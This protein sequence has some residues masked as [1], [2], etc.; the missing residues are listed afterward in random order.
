LKKRTIFGFKKKPKKKKFEEKTF[1][2]KK[3]EKVFKKKKIKSKNGRL[4]KKK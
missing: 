1:L 3:L 2:K 4:K